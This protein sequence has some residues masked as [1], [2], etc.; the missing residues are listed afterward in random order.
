MN[1]LQIC[2]V[3]VHRQK[4]KTRLFTKFVPRT[5][6]R[7]PMMSPTDENHNKKSEKSI[8]MAGSH[9]L[10]GFT[11]QLNAQFVI[12]CILSEPDICIVLH[13]FCHVSGKVF[14]K[15]CTIYHPSKVCMHSSVVNFKLYI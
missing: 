11:F 10:C 3:F 8:Q 6:N 12:I 9:V 14:V 15:Y 13:Y 1:N 2:Q 4:N 7:S 5:R